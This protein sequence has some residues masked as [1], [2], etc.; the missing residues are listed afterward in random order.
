VNIGT[1]TES[2][3]KPTESLHKRTKDRM[4]AETASIGI[5]L[6]LEHG[7]DNVTVE[8]IC[9][10]AGLSRR[11]FFRYFSAKEEIVMSVFADLADRG[12][13]AFL[14]RPVDD[15]LWAAL[16]HSMDPMIEW[17]AADPDRA[18]AIIRLIDA[19]PSLRAAFLDRVDSWRKLLAGVVSRRLGLEAA[20]DLYAAVVAAAAMGAFVS[21]TRAWA[22]AGGRDPLGELFDEAFAAVHPVELT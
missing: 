11:S 17:A 2:A 15:A 8:D 1:S 9:A 13:R 21:G 14:H 18:V 4:R 7:F 12:W 20:N 19:S 10:A 16:R 5:Q 22:D 3:A 6:F